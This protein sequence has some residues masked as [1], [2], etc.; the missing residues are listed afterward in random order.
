MRIDDSTADLICIQFTNE[1]RNGVIASLKSLSRNSGDVC[2]V[3]GENGRVVFQIVEHGFK[4]DCSEVTNICIELP[5]KE[6]NDLM[7]AI[8]EH[9]DE[10]SEWSLDHSFE[11]LG[12]DIS[13]KH[14][15]DVVI[16]TI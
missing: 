15:S 12:A 13:P 3:H 7:D 9:V 1:E 8:Q 5:Q 16:E 10:A 11:S 6:C 14:I 4:I 2:V